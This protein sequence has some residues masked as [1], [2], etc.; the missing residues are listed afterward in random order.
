MVKSLELFDSW[1]ADYPAG[2]RLTFRSLFNHNTGLTAE[3]QA[4]PYNLQKKT[5]SDILFLNLKWR[6]TTLPLDMHMFLVN[7]ANKRP[8]GTS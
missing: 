2:T 5:T 3:Q 7:L 1:R 8:S 6:F 4:D